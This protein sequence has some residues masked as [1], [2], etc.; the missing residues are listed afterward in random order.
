MT[1]AIQNK[2]AP[3]QGQQI[4]PAAKSGMSTFDKIVLAFI[5]LGLTSVVAYQVFF[6][7][8]CYVGG[9]RVVG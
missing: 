3:A 4:Q 2:T 5:I 7:V 8:N 1:N 6:C 9:G